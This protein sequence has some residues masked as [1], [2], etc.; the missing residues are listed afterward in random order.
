VDATDQRLDRELST[1][2]GLDSWLRTPA[3]CA[4]QPNSDLSADASRLPDI[5]ATSVVHRSLTHA[6]ECLSAAGAVIPGGEWMHAPFVLLRGAYE[7]AAL[8][9]WLL[10]P[11]S[12]DVRLTRLIAQHGDSWKYSAKAYSGT[13]LEDG[14]LHDE[15]RQYVTRMIEV[16]GVDPS[17][18]RLPGFERLIESVDD[19]PGQGESLLTAWRL[20]SGVSHAKTWALNEVSVEVDRTGEFEHGHI[21]ARVANPGLAITLLGVGRRTVQRARA[22]CA[23]R[24]T[25]RP[26]SIRVEMRSIP[27]GG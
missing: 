18:C 21:S 26:H 6:V 12:V 14:G 15:R 1:L 20:C 13:T 9:E 2:R 25:A 27:T 3:A 4:A 5:W 19:F 8:A 17:E 11:D 10:E 22:L 23:V 24:T 16:A 7:S